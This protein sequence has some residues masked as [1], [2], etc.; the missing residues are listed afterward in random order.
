MKYLIIGDI[1][2]EIE[3]VKKFEVYF[4]KVDQVIYVGDYVDRCPN[5]LAVLQFVLE[6]PNAIRLCG[7]HEWKYRKKHLKGN[8][9]APVDITTDEQFEQFVKLFNDVIGEK[10]TFY[11]KDQNIGV[12][13]APGALHQH[14]WD[15]I[16]RDKFA[17][18]WTSKEKDPTTGHPRRLS[19]E[20]VY[21]N[22]ISI[23]PVIFGHTHQ[24]Q[25]VIRENEYCID[26]DS[27]NVDGKLCGV[28]FEDS[29]FK[30]VYFF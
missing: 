13:H 24:K 23:K 19:L 11:Y 9:A 28:I 2:G 7:N 16:P 25:L 18:S 14:D 30:D 4:D 10:P 3:K 21:N 26:F 22:E 6:T 12:S 17:Y 5:T 27:G 15:K 8:K 20:T 29:V 1:H